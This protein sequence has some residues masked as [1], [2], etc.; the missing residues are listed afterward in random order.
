MLTVGIDLGTTATVIAVMRDGKP[1]TVCVDSGKKTTPS[2]VNYSEYNTETN[3]ITIGRNALSK[4]DYSNTIFSIKRS[5]GSNKKFFHRTPEEISADILSFVKQVAEQKLSDVINTAV[6][7]VPAHFSDVQRIA[8]KRA[9]S[10]AGIKVLRLINEPT[11]AAI[12]FGLEKKV[13]GIYAVYD[14]GGGTFD[15]SILRLSQDGIFQV[16]ATGGDNYLGGDDIDNEIL[17]YNFKKHNID[18]SS[19]DASEKL[20]GKLLVKTMKELCGSN[21]LIQK[22]FFWKNN[23]YLF[24][25]SP[26]MLSNISKK[27]IDR[28]F[29]I[30]D[31]VFSDAKLDYRSIDGVLL[32]GGMTKMPTVK[33]AVKDR[34]GGRIFDDIDPEEVVAFGAAIQAN[35]IINKNTDALLIDVVPLTLGIETLG[36]GVDKI[37][38]RNTPIPTIQ[39]RE[40]TTYKDNQTGIKFHVVQGERTMAS[41]CRSIANFELTGIPPTMRGIPRIEVTFSID[42]NGL[43]NVKAYEK[44]TNIEQ[45][46]IVEPSSGLT[47]EQMISMLQNAMNNLEEDKKKSAYVSAKISAERQISFWENILEDIPYPEK[48]EIEDNIIYL[49]Q[50]LVDETKSSDIINTINKIDDIVG[51]FLD[52]II[53]LRLSRNPIKIKEKKK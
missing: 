45:N 1:Q 9:A 52:D 36:G 19:I 47:E 5:M 8:T 50:I 3:K 21:E 32:V 25:I 18:I 10:L 42:V 39:T 31:Q 44:N 26:E 11:A 46:I 40:Y 49:K 4:V 29:K 28:T 30:A 37:I 23:V 7:T 48:R 6:I 27:Y 53:S 2:V 35:A 14:F 33:K 12:A 51:R 41:D 17:E 24:E 16:L 20:Q 15:F 38:H 13:A 22:E 43:L 34:F